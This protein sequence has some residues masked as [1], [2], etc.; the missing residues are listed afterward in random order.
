MRSD[1]VP[2]QMPMQMPP[3][4]RAGRPPRPGA[5]AGWS[6]ALLC[7]GL[8]GC[9]TTAP[10]A[11]PSASPRGSQAP[12]DELA[13]WRQR[14]IDRAGQFEA[15]GQWPQALLLWQGLLL[16]RPQDPRAGAEVT[17]LAQRIDEAARDH[18]Q[19]GDDALRRH[20]L[21]GAEHH[22]AHLLGLRPG[23]ARALQALRQVEA[24][25]L[26]RQPAAP[27]MAG[28]APASAPTPRTG[29]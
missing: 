16:L 9:G 1:P 17:R 18:E 28:S 19:R 13:A 6:I 10:P 7:A 5:R 14:Q 25:R 27:P 26:R 20:D 24:Q 15:T 21:D 11:D 12:G 4:S 3:R 22:F 23:H 8:T 29:P 2:M